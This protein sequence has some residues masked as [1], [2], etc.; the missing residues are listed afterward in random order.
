[1]TFNREHYLSSIFLIDNEVA[2]GNLAMD[3]FRHQYAN[4]P[5]YR[6][7]ADNIGTDVLKIQ[8]FRKIPFLPIELYKNHTISCSSGNFERV[9]MSSGTTS[10]NKSK[11]YISDTRVYI[12]S[13]IK[14]FRLF[15][16]EPGNYNIL[17]LLPGYNEESSLVFM[18]NELIRLSES[19]TSGFYIGQD[20]KLAELLPTLTN[21]KI[22]L[23]GVTHALLDF[24][25]DYHFNLPDLTVIETGGMKGRGK[26]L[27]R[28][29]VHTLLKQG[30]GIQNVCSEYGMTE[31][32]SQAYSKADGIFS[33]PH[34]MKVLARDLNDPLSLISSGKSGGINVIDLANIDTCS[35]IATSDYGKVYDDGRFDISGR[36]D[37]SDLRGCNLMI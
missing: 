1:M 12:N 23:F 25:K 36:I 30:F 7:F 11:H 8:D 22:I 16:G 26:E 13:F 15:F 17:A 5:V 2:F 21:R 9:F 3:A 20:R 33:C 4:N 34:W 10:E 24:T 14:G 32:F 31:L 28:E 19:K 18:V 29:E 37:Y 27:I 35:F 6:A